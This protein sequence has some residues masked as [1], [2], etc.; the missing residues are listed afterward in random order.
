MYNI[1][2]N[3]GVNTPSCLKKMAY[4]D[5]ARKWAD[6]YVSERLI[7]DENNPCSEE[8]LQSSRTANLQVY[9]GEPIAMEKGEATLKEP[10]Y[11]SATFYTD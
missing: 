10:V 8:V 6:D 5:E 2:V 1:F 3:D 11:E 4:L 9:D 7:V